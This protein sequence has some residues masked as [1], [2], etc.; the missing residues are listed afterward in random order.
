MTEFEPSIRPAIYIESISVKEHRKL[1]GAIAAA[2]S[3]GTVTWI[4]DSAGI[5]YAAI[6]PRGVADLGLRAVEED[7]KALTEGEP[8]PRTVVVSHRNSRYRV[9]TLKAPEGT[10]PF[11]FSNAIDF[12]SKNQKDNAMPSEEEKYL[13]P[14]ELA[15][16]RKLEPEVQQHVIRIAEGRQNLPEATRRKNALTRMEPAEAWPY[17]LQKG[18][19][20]DLRRSLHHGTEFLRKTGLSQTDSEGNK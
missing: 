7:V 5:A 11:R 15:Q 8:A 9:R 20:L 3:D 17:A 2:Q 18:I 19:E 4:K 16:F 12:I 14:D 6:V 13:S 1:R 10:G